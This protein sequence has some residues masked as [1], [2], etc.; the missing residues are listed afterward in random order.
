MK[1]IEIKF[2]GGDGR[3]IRTVNEV[4]ENLADIGVDSEHK[5]PSSLLDLPAELQPFTTQEMEEICNDIWYPALPA[6]TNVTATGTD[7]EFD[8]VEGAE[9]YIV[10]A[11]GVEIGRYTPPQ[12]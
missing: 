8:E 12:V 2:K 6:P 10:Y 3:R 7:I 1:S 11:D 5:I 4:P 9:E